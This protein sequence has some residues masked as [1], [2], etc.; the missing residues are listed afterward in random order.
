MDRLAEINSS[1]RKMY[2][3]MAHVRRDHEIFQLLKT[4]LK[5][6]GNIFFF[7]FNTISDI[8]NKLIT[9]KQKN[10]KQNTITTS[11]K[12]QKKKSTKTTKTNGL[13]YN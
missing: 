13:L 1:K 12:K 9:T 4:S 5:C 8:R 11:F 6:C 3:S 7:L 10:A 2:I